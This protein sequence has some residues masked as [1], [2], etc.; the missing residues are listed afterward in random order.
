VFAAGGPPPKP[1]N[2]LSPAAALER[3]RF[4]PEVVQTY[5]ARAR[6]QCDF[7]EGIDPKLKP[8]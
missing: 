3:L 5:D 8:L 6:H 7:W 1:E 4:S 2:V